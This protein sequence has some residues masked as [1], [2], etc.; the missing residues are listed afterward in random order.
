MHGEVRQAIHCSDFQSLP[1]FTLSSKF[2]QNL[3]A[4]RKKNYTS[5]RVLVHSLESWKL[6]N[7]MKSFGFQPKLIVTCLYPAIN[8]MHTSNVKLSFNLALK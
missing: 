2:G 5:Q 1:T 4:E 7:Y 8:L 3:S 6:L